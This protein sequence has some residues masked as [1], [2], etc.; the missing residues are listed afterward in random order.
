MSSRRSY[1]ARLPAHVREEINQKLYDGW[2]FQ[3]IADWLFRQTADRD[4]PDLNLKTGEPYSLVWTRTAKDNKTARETCR[5]RIA[6]WYHTH[7]PDWLEE[8]V[9]TGQAIRIFDRTEQLSAAAREK[10]AN[11][12][13]HGADVIIRA[14]LLDTITKL[15]EQGSDPDKL[16]D[17]INTWAKIR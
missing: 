7:Y 6:R 15:R 8:T 1:I 3:T 14:L 11:G 10:V 4:I 16:I 13:R 12:S 5:S 2:Q 17:L 9:E